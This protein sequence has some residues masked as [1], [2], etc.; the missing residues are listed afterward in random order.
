[1]PNNSTARKI[2]GLKTLKSAYILEADASM[3]RGLEAAA[4]GLFLKAGELEL[5]LAEIFRSQNDDA[6]AQVSFL[7]AGSCYLRAKQYRS[8]IKWLEL[9]AVQFP[10]TRE[11]IAQCEGKEDL[12]L[13][14]ATPGLQA[15]IGLLVKKGMIEESEWAQALAG[16]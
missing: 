6:N 5:E 1:M 4:M 12:P 9:A 2:E 11:L 15:L 8:A 14:A 7:S 3:A 16:H 13:N 10:E